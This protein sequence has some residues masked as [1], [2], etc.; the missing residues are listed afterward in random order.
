MTTHFINSV[1]SRPWT[2]EEEKHRQEK[3]KRGGKPAP[4][5]EKK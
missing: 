1:D 4:L 2:V 5:P 3:L